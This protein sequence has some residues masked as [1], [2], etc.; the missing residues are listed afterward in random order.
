MVV[1]LPLTSVVIGR[2][3]SGSQTVLVFGR[4]MK[5]AQQGKDRRRLSFAPGSIFCCLTY[6]TKPPG[7]GL[8]RLDVLRAVAPGERCSRISGATPGAEI[9]VRARRAADIKQVRTLIAAIHA[10]GFNPSDA[11]ASFWVVVHNRL[12]AREALPVFSILAHAAAVR[13]RELG[14]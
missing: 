14:L 8:E 9:L 2:L 1:S 10:E 13:R 6:R 11:S 7:V 12:R 5:A 4:P 3:R